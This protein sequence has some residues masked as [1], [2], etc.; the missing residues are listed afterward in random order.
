MRFITNPADA[1]AVHIISLGMPEVGRTRVNAEGQP[2]LSPDG[3]VTHSTGVVAAR[4]DGGQ[5]RGITI[6]VIDYKPFPMGTPLRMDGGV[7]VTPYVTDAKRQGLSFICE[8]LVPA[9]P[10]RADRTAS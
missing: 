8:R 7:W 4:E 1:A 6:A 9:T 5:D 3:R 10:A 2:K